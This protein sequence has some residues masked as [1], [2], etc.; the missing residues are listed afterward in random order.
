MEQQPPEVQNILCAALGTGQILQDR[1]IDVICM[2]IFRKQKAVASG[3][4]DAYHVTD[5]K[6]AADVFQLVVV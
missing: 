5:R 4:A 2:W 1:L 3:G 6:A